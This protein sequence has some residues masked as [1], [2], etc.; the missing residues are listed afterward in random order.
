[1]YLEGDILQ[2]VDRAS[3]ACSLEVRVPLLNHLLVEWATALPDEL[4][5]VTTTRRVEPRSG[6]WTA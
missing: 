3:M 1:M 6:A 5:A 2:K 4:V